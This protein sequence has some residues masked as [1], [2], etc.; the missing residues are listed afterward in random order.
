MAAL[1][2]GRHRDV[3]DSVARLSGGGDVRL[4]RSLKDNGLD[5]E[6]RLVGR[7]PRRAVWHRRALR[8]D[9]TRTGA[10][11]RAASRVYSKGMAWGWA[12]AAWGVSAALAVGSVSAEDGV[13]RLDLERYSRRPASPYHWLTLRP[14]ESRIER[15][16]HGAAVFEGDEP[17][18]AVPLPGVLLDCKTGEP[19]SPAL[20]LVGLL[21]WRRFP[22]EP[23]ARQWTN[24][25]DWFAAGWQ[26]EPYYAEAGS[27]AWRRRDGAGRFA[28][29]VTVRRPRWAYSTDTR[30]EVELDPALL[31]RA[32]AEPGAVELAVE[33]PGLEVEALF[34]VGAPTAR[35][36]EAC[37]PT[38]AAD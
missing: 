8:W 2:Y 20:P 3:P 22:A 21:T 14:A 32:F 24:P 19:G 4:P 29:A 15:A 23:F 16:G 34:R 7:S 9:G 27:L 12:A 30:Y 6:R 18:R 17:E 28:Q 36:I 33:A 26:W 10:T 13:P 37:G 1:G 5:G 38:A 11:V 25:L 35:F 31:A